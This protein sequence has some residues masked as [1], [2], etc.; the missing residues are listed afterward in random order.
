[1]ARVAII[2]VGAVGARLARQLV[3]TDADEVVLRDEDHA[4]AEMVAQSLGE[5]SRVDTS[6][7][8]A[9]LDVD[10]VVLAGRP[11]VHAKQAAALLAGGA[12]IVSRFPQLAPTSKLTLIS[13]SQQSLS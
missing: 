4:R 6:G 9:P 12:P 5:R 13:F 2:G 1:M 10:V 11:R 8:T 7:L 3:S